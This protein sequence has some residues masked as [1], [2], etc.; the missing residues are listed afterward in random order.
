MQA[1][2]AAVLTLFFTLGDFHKIMSG[3]HAQ[4][5]AF[6]IPDDSGLLAAA[7]VTGNFKVYHPRSNQNVP[8]RD[9]SFLV[10]SNAADGGCGNRV[11]CDCTGWY[12]DTGLL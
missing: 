11:L 9:V 12:R 8:P 7:F 2:G 3:R 4:A 6:L 10:G 1:G 5:L